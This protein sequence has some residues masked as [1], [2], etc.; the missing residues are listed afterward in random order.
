MKNAVKHWHCLGLATFLVAASPLWSFDDRSAAGYFP[1]QVLRDQ[2]G[3]AVRFYSDLLQGKTVVIH[4]FFATCHDA[5]PA[6]FGKLKAIQGSFGDHLGKDL[7]F[8]SISVDPAND[9][10]AALHEVAGSLGAKNGWYFLSGSKQNVD[11]VLYKLGQF[12]P[13]REEHSTTFLVGNEPAGVWTKIDAALP[14]ETLRQ[15]VEKALQASTQ[16]TK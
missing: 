12:A 13:I 10:P 9:V 3:K 15:G 6:M 5:C 4:S 8:L 1:N 7:L 2:N 11:W 14:V 16:S